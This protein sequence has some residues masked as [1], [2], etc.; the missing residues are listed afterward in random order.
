MWSF[1][2]WPA[3]PGRERCQVPVL[4][5]RDWRGPAAAGGAGTRLLI[6]GGGTSAVE[7]A[8]ESAGAA[9]DVTLAV[10]GKM[11]LAPSTLL[12]RDV[13]HYIG[14]L[15]RLPPWLARGY[16]ARRPTLPAS[17]HGFSRLRAAGRVTVRPGL[18]H[19]EEGG[20]ATF[21]DGTSAA[22]DR[23]VAA[24]GYRFETPF[25]P[26]EVERAPAG[27][28]VARHNESRSWPGLFVVG[29]PCSNRLDSEFLRGMARD[30]A[31]VARAIAARL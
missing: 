1:P 23:I 14:P 30:A 8:E 25:L 26:P 19:L 9:L 18:A 13:H 21:V 4:H 10:R 29:A 24:T 7:L 5:A 20:R 12:G 17:D 15:E 31:L 11:R 16:C 28:V 22:F 27:Q 3:L 6:I 2:V